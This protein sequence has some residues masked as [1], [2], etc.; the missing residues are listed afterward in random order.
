MKFIIN[1]KKLSDPELTLFCQ[2]Y[3]Y[4]NLLDKIFLKKLDILK[5]HCIE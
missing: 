2:K 1:A 4:K 3:I 5:K